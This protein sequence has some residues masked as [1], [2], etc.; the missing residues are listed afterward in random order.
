MGQDFKKL[1]DKQAKRT[2]A[3]KKYIPH[4]YTGGEKNIH[5]H[6]FNGHPDQ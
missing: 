6:S 2:D 4:C 3:C 1:Y 5:F